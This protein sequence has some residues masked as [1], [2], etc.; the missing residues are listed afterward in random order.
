V[1]WS[2][3]SPAPGRNPHPPERLEATVSAPKPPALS[4]P[5]LI[6]PTSILNQP[7]SGPRSA[8]RKKNRPYSHVHLEVDLERPAAPD[9]PALRR[10]EELLGL[11]RIEES[12]DLIRLTG[13][14]LHALSAL[15]FRRVDHWEVAPGGWLPLPDRSGRP[16]S[17]EPVGHLLD[18]LASDD[19][20]PIAQARSFSLRL[21]GIG[22][23][24]ADIVIRRAHRRSR[25]SVSLDLH[26]TWT[27]DE[28][29]RLRGAL[30]ARLPV[31][32]SEM[33]KFQ[34]QV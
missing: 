14:T 12:A 22:G 1:T 7:T 5:G 4:A 33:T 24:H 13:A 19:W 3:D 17:D 10:L 6:G 2:V 31:Q 16:K 28:V 32:R 26:G 15:G 25:H 21:S 30:A 27:H 11:R 23:K 29:E 9:T 20:G 18:A 8:R 34:F